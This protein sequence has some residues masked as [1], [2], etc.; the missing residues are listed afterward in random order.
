MTIRLTVKAEDDE[1][2]TVRCTFLDGD[3]DVIAI[4]RIASILWT[5]TDNN[6][7]V[8]NGRL[9]VAPAIAN[10][11]D[12]VLSGED[13]DFD[14][15]PERLL[16]VTVL[17][18]ALTMTKEVLFWIEDPSAPLTFKDFM[19][20]D[21]AA[22]FN[23]DE[24]AEEVTYTPTGGVAVV[25][26]A[27]VEAEQNQVMTGARTS[28]IGSIYIRGSEVASP[29]YRDSVTINGTVWRVIQVPG[30]ADAGVWKLGIQRDERPT[31]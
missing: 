12:I 26:G 31:L 30:C 28:R 14:N 29:G 25:V 8:V 15:G 9:N 13:T 3:D 1:I 27:I 4:G 23:V 7:T 16:S 2:Y 20:D 11:L 19:A 6:G 5:M 17:Y 18:D 24:F 22:F 21:L 10:P